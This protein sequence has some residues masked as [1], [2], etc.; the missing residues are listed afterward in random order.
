MGTY[1]LFA[2]INKEIITDVG[3]LML[4]GYYRQAEHS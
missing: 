1:F 4:Q 3:L 2:A